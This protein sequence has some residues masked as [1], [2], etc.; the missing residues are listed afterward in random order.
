MKLN[1]FNIEEL[2]NRNYEITNPNAINNQGEFEPRGVYSEEIF[3]KL[4]N[5]SL[6]NYSCRCGHLQGKF[7]ENLLECPECGETVKQQSSMMRRNGFIN[8]KDY[9]VI[10]PYYYEQL[11]RLIGRSELTKVLSYEKGLDIEGNELDDCEEIKEEFHSLGIVGFKEKFED[12]LEHY[13]NISNNANAEKI[14]YTLLDRKDQVFVS[15]IPV[16]T[17]KLRPAMIK[18]KEL[19]YDKVNNFFTRIINANNYLQELT[20]EER[21][22]IITNPLLLVIQEMYVALDEHFSNALSGKGGWFRNSFLANY[23]NFSARGVITPLAAKYDMDEIHIPY[24]FALKL[25]KFHII[26]E[27]SKKYKYNYSQA[28]KRHK[29]AYKKID[30]EILVIMQSLLDKSY[31]ITTDGKKRKG[32]HCLLNRNPT[33]NKGSIL[34]TRITKVKTDITDLTIGLNTLLL[35][36]LAGD[37]DGDAL[38]IF[39]LPDNKSISV[40]ERFSPMDQIVSNIDGNF[41]PFMFLGKDHV[42]GITSLCD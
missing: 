40:F 2:Y 20:E 36:V 11:S 12:V 31:Y 15:I 35:G 38:N 3:G 28:N 32:Y 22:V 21:S 18:N 33:I 5:S 34:L 13:V 27:L 39:L 7:Y 29:N 1:V 24:Y 37:F 26:N 9:E 17:S 41:N 14:Y 19:S 42:L 4:N 30:D 25:F 23:L 10:H 8:L 6:Y 16:I